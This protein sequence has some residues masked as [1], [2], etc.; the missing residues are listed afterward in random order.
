MNTSESVALACK[1]EDAKHSTEQIK[2]ESNSVKKYSIKCSTPPRVKT[3][4]KEAGPLWDGCQ[5][6]NVQDFSVIRGD[7]EEKLKGQK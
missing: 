3:A 4:G 5:L 7:S 6:P 1:G 2:V